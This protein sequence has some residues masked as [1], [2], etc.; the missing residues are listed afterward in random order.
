MNKSIA[1]LACLAALSACSP[2]ISNSPVPETSYFPPA[3]QKFIASASHWQIIAQDLAAQI[4]PTLSGRVSIS[5][6]MPQSPFS[7]V[8]GTM[9]ASQLAERHIVV[10]SNQSDRYADHLVYHVDV[11]R[12]GFARPASQAL[13][14]LV[15]KNGHMVWAPLRPGMRPTHSLRG[16]Q[17]YAPVSE[18]VLSVDV[19]RAG[20]RVSGTTLVYYVRES[21]ITNY[22]PP[23][24]VVVPAVIAPL[25]DRKAMPDKRDITDHGPRKVVVIDRYGE[26]TV[27]MDAQH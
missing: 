4:S 27:L 8:F 24:P 25:P 2:T 10:V 3:Q 23:L 17:P 12:T 9:L 1:G 20:V 19:E 22:M 14:V 11:V 16:T 13:E 18:V 5:Q 21:D 7:D 15:D 26:K 6:S